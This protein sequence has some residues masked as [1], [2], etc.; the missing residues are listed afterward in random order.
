MI[1]SDSAPATEHLLLGFPQF[2]G[3][4]GLLSDSEET[5]SA[6]IFVHGF[7]GDAVETWQQF[8]RLVDAPQYAQ[9]FARADLFFYA[10]PSI[11]YTITVAT[12]HLEAFVKRMLDGPWEAAVDSRTADVEAPNRSYKSLLLVGHS[13]GG[14]LVRN[15]IAKAANAVN[16]RPAAWPMLVG[17]APQLFAPATAGFRHDDV[18]SLAVSLSK[19]VTFIFVFWRLR[20][21]RVYADLR[22]GSVPLESVRSETERARAEYKDC[23]ALYA[24]VMWGEEENVV[25]D[26]N[27]ADDRNYPP[28][29]GGGRSI[30]G[31]NHQTICKPTD[32]FDEPVQMVIHGLE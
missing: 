2:P 29:A 32:G 12:Q 20:H 14:V 30:A 18:V 22:S 10:Y 23:P 7:M 26:I 4:Y 25:F 6:V 28:D 1:P 5:D 11:K 13:L 3:A 8:Q 16:A 21:A 27:Y 19:V 17:R 31:K 9:H 15:A 24:D